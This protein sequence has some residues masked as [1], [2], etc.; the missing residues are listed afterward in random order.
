MGKLV[1][2]V[3]QAD[4][5]PRAP[6]MVAGMDPDGRFALSE[7]AFRS[8]VT[9]NGR[10]GPTGHDGF[11]AARGRYQLYVSL[12][13]PWAHAALI[14][15]ALKGLAE[16]VPVSVTHWRL[17]DQGWSFDAGEGVVPDP[18]LKAHYLHEI[19]SHA[20]PAYTGRVTVPLLLDRHTQAI[21]NNE[22]ADIVRMF[23]SAFDE[24]G[25]NTADF[26]PEALRPRIDSWNAR[27]Q[28]D[29][30]EAVYRGGLAP[31][32]AQ[33]QAAVDRLFAAFEALEDHLATNRFLCGDTLTEAD[34][35][36]FPTLLRFDAVYH[37]LFRCR[38]KYLADHPNLWAYT[39]DIYQW[40]A[41]GG[42]VAA[43]VN[44]RHIRRHYYESLPSLNPSGEVPE[45]AVP[46]FTEPA[47]R[48][49]D[50][51]RLLTF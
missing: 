42:A 5:T 13:C 48:E 18:V 46:D 34:I 3:W 30:T 41:P 15:H 38:R 12:A 11:A 44:M 6:N 27:I 35:R 23:N 51:A 45:T 39:R 14:M 4:E 2:G 40:P 24:M 10:P 49:R 26:Y 9:R 17:G 43:T 21:V 1:D 25:A 7:G 31:T 28:Q 29:V 32:A 33:H 20:D 22:S 36:L 47:G 37:D 50:V 19:Y 16:I 8:W